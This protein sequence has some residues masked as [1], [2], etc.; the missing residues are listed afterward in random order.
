M[1]EDSI[2]AFVIDLVDQEL[3]EVLIEFL[4]KEYI[5][6]SW[7]GQER[8]SEAFLYLLQESLFINNYYLLAIKP[9]KSRLANG[10][11]SKLAISLNFNDI[12]FF[13]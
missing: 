5:L 10:H 2:C 6:S 1:P 12:A 11:H 3:V 9:N 8:I 7:L 4:G 13:S